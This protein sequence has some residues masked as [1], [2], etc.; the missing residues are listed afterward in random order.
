M[1]VIPLN[2]VTRALRYV[3]PHRRLAANS[4]LLTI[5]T[6]VVTLATPW[7]LAIVIDHAL[8]DKPLPA[9]LAPVVTPFAHTPSGLIIF[10]VSASL[11]LLLILNALHVAS[12]FVNTK[13]DQQIT[14][15]VRSQ[16]FLHSQK[17]SLAF[18]DKSRAGMLIYLINSQGDAPA[19]LVMT[20]PMLIEAALTLV[21]MFWISSKLDP[22]LALVSLTVVP[23]LYFSVGYYSAKIQDRLT[24]VRTLESN[25]LSIIHE[26]FGMMRV[27]VAFCREDHEYKRFRDQTTLAVGERVKITVRQTIFSLVV[28]FITAIGTA[29]VLGLGAHHVLAAKQLHYPPGSLTV[30][31]LTVILAYLAQFYRPLEQISFTVGS[32]QDKF[33]S[34]KTAFSLLDTQPD[35]ADAPGAKD[36]SRARGGVKFERVNFSYAGRSDT[37]K[38]I[39]FEAKPGQVI[40]IVGPTGAGKSTLVSLIP[41]YYDPKH[42]DG[43]IL[44]DGVDSH[45]LTLK[46]LRAQIS[47]VLQ[48]PLLF[49]GSIKENIRY[50]RLEATDAEIIAA[51]KAANAHDFIERL[52]QK[53]ETILG[54]RGAQISGGERQRISVARA[55]LKD[56]PILILDEPTSSVDSKTEAVILEALERLMVGRTT[57]MIAHRLSTLKHADQVLVINQGEL[58]EHGTQ[59]ELIAKNG[60]Y[61]QLYD[62]QIAAVRQSKLATATA[63]SV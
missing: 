37:L 32:L 50:G 11:L 29:L 52:P 17:M 21:G 60:L 39:S 15:D 20:I 2:Y 27:I 58:V 59:D 56:A 41:R 9:W 44:I 13:I 7:P 34:L 43:R 35:I 24:R 46:S 51:A 16:L 63:Q 28:N 36:I 23:F 4:V 12:N 55:F 14:L 42:G 33:V 6:A 5:L 25:S 31:E 30:G 45:D 62:A 53:Y 3:L 40:G 18:H 1:S 10:A 61:K 57:F 22:T 48:E 54:E 49:S 26:A 38:N 19:G 8:S 47:I